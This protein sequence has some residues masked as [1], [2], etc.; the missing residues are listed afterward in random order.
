MHDPCDLCFSIST[1][2]CSCRTLSSWSNAARGEVGQEV[3]GIWVEP[4]Y[5]KKRCLLLVWKAISRPPLASLSCSLPTLA[6]FRRSATAKFASRD[7][8]CVRGQSSKQSFLSSTCLTLAVRQPSSEKQPPA[9]DFSMVRAQLV[10]GQHGLFHNLGSGV[11]L[12]F[13]VATVFAF[14]ASQLEVKYAKLISILSCNSTISPKA[15]CS[16]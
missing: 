11:L 4:G 10:F 9:M 16:Q 15:C 3:E 5:A 2:S 6:S 14:A 12:K 13:S 8:S 7:R 1:R